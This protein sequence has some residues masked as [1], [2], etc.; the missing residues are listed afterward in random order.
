MEIRKGV[1]L[2]RSGDGFLGKVTLPET[3]RAANYVHVY[4]VGGLNS[5]WKRVIAYHYTGAFVNGE[6]LRDCLRFNQPL[7]RHFF[8]CAVRDM[9]HGE[10]QPCDVAELKPVKLP[11]LCH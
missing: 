4:R 5:R 10:L 2:D 9:R 8:A 3:D 7:C 1:E 11:L 6:K